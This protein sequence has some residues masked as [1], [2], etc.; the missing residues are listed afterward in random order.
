MEFRSLDRWDYACKVTVHADI[1]VVEKS[2]A[3]RIELISN[4]AL[5]T[6]MQ[7]TFSGSTRSMSYRYSTPSGKRKSDGA[8]EITFRDIPTA[9][10]F[11]AMLRLSDGREIASSARLSHLLPARAGSSGRFIVFPSGFAIE[12]PGSYN[13]SIELRPD[14]N[15]AYEDPAIKAIWNGTLEFPISFTISAEPNSP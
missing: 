14:P 10:G 13:G 2:Q 6:A 5:D 4:P 12:E 15:A 3:E 7:A 11:E 9:V 1:V 8:L